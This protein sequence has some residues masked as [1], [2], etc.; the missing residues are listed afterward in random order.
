M[1]RRP[2]APPSPRPPRSRPAAARRTTPSVGQIQDFCTA[3]SGARRCTRQT[4]A[5]GA[6]LREG[7]L[8]PGVLPTANV[9]PPLPVSKSAEV[10]PGA[11]MSALHIPNFER[12]PMSTM[13]PTDINAALVN[14]VRRRSPQRWQTIPSASLPSC[15]PC[16]PSRT[17][18]PCP[19]C[20]RA[21]PVDPAGGRPAR[22]D[23][24]HPPPAYRPGP[25]RPLRCR[26]ESGVALSALAASNPDAL[27]GGDWEPPSGHLTDLTRGFPPGDGFYSDEAGP[28]LRYLWR[29]VCY[30]APD[31]LVEVALTDDAGRRCGMAG[32]RRRCRHHGCRCVERRRCPGRRLPRCGL[33]TPVPRRARNRA[34][35][36]PDHPLDPSQRCPQLPLVACLQRIR[37]T[38]FSGPHL[39]RRTSLPHPA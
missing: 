4:V 5:W 9:Y 17:P 15:A 8:G 1:S 29:W 19:G 21:S 7:L 10:T 18:A 30:Q 35:P 14:L 20:P 24:G 25:V 26:R 12:L 33:G 16:W 32:Q 2:A 34:R 11:I 36:A 27:A 37:H 13:H 6:T 3:V 31:L 23:H 22:R 38:A 28:E 39:P